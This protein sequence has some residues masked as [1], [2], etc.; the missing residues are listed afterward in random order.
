MCM[1]T[2][3]STSTC[4]YKKDTTRVIPHSHPQ[5]LR[6]YDPLCLP[7]KVEH[8]VMHSFV[9][10][11]FHSRGRFRNHHGPYTFMEGGM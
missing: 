8:V 7:W 11:L 10:I 5:M 1:M 9:V 3:K 6:R 2:T 4:I